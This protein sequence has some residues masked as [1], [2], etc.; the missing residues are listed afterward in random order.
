[1]PHTFCNFYSLARSHLFIRAALC[2]TMLAPVLRPMIPI[3]RGAHH[4]RARRFS[5]I[6]LAMRHYWYSGIVATYRRYIAISNLGY[7]YILTFWFTKLLQIHWSR[8]STTSHDFSRL[9]VSYNKLTHLNQT[10]HKLNCDLKKF[11]KS[12]STTVTLR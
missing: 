5:K 9:R 7:L 2:E 6:G 3:Q 11:A 8:R 1:M 4:I 10:L 12:K